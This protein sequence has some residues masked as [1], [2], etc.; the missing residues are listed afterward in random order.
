MAHISVSAPRI[1]RSSRRA[2]VKMLVVTL[3]VAVPAF[4]LGY[5]IWAPL[6]M[7]PSPGQLPFFHGC[8]LLRGSS[9]GVRR[10]VPYLWTTRGAPG[11]TYSDL[12]CS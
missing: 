4:V 3:L 1:V 10:F 11:C 12:Q 7:G 8:Q 6:G 2:W 5:I 9:V